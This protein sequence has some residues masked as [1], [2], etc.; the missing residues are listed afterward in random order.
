MKK[1]TCPGCGREIECDSQPKTSAERQK[2]YRDRKSKLAVTENATRYVTRNGNGG[3]TRQEFT[4]PTIA[5]VRAHCAERRNAVDPETFVAFYE[6]KGW[7]V[8]NQP[9]KSWKAAIVTWEKR[10]AT[11]GHQRLYD[12]LQACAARAEADGTLDKEHG[13]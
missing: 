9:M 8:G 11:N 5:D 2:A 1:H 10:I 12:S 13:T 6:S 3:V 7:K 4:K